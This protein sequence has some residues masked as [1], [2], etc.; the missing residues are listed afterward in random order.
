MTM[1]EAAMNKPNNKDIEVTLEHYTPLWVGSN[2]TRTCWASQESSD[3]TEVMECLEPGCNFM[4]PLS[5]LDEM[6]MTELGILVCPECGSSEVRIYKRT[7]EA[8]K[9]LIDRVGNKFKHA[10]T[11]EHLYYN[12]HITGISRACLQ[13]VARHRITSPSVKST[14][15]TLKEL[16]G[17]E[18][19]ITHDY[20]SD[21]ETFD[22]K[23]SRKYLVRTGNLDVDEAGIMALENLRKLLVV[24]IS[25]DVAKYSLPESYKTELAWSINARSLQN[26]LSLRSNKAAL[27][28]I[29]D[30]AYDIFNALPE[31]HKFLFEDSMYVEPVKTP[32]T[33]Q[34]H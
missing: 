1:K 27:W 20:G 31:E 24:G 29:R 33:P 6:P 26:F 7:G 18:P 15:Y 17:E 30:L 21:T 3:T 4:E 11:L 13:E 16:K 14:R 19:F 5:D 32:T 22:Y 12:F 2:A 34:G 9:S 8:D 25:N 28:E 23:R 10:S